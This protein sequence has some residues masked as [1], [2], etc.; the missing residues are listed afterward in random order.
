MR[1]GRLK[2]RAYTLLFVLVFLAAAI[3][4]AGS[5]VQFHPVQQWLI[6]RLSAAVGYEISSGPVNLSC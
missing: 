2:L 1:T 4:L 5:L 6:E 3:L